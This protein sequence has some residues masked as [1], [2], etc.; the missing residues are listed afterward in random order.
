MPELNYLVDMDMDCASHNCCALGIHFFTWRLT[1][2]H[3]PFPKPLLS[4]M[5]MI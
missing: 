4:W 2:I 3:F 1:F 5:M